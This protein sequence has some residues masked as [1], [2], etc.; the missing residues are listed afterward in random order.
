MDLYKAEFRENDFIYLR[1]QAQE[2]LLFANDHKNSN[3]LIYGCLDTRIAL[4]ILDLKKILA[5]VNSSEINIII[6]ESKPKNGI[7][8]INKKQGS[9]KERY[10][11]FYQ[12][13]CELLGVNDKY[14][15]FKKSKDLQ[16]KLSTYIH[17]YYMTQD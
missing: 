16:H 7:D 11:L 10:Q 5:S 9:L 3:A 1:R 15:D 12:A 17:S 2:L 13:V 8:R 4:E 6:E 14:Y